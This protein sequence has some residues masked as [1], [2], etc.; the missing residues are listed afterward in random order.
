MAVTI[1]G[2]GQVP[3]QVI[4]TVKTDV[5]TTSST[6]F[7]DVTGLSAT[8][9]PKSASNKILVIV[10]SYSSPNL[11]NYTIFGKL[12]RG[13]TDIA[14]GDARGSTTRCSFNSS[15]PNSSVAT[16]WGTSF[17]DSPATTSATTY[18]VQ[19]AAESGST[20]TVGGSSSSANSYNTSVPTVLTLMEIA[21]A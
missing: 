7:V 15:Y 14:I 1:N 5:F 17:L 4:Q 6:S 19:A 12:V 8:I 3:V 2:S 18:K 11:G 13:A 21:Y 16:A 10:S 20:A 9:T